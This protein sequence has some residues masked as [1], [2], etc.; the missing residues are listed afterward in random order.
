[1]LVL[2]QVDLEAFSSKSF[3]SILN[4][5]SKSVTS[6]IGL[7]KDEVK[8]LFQKILEQVF[9]LKGKESLVY[10]NYKFF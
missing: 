7:Q 3:Y 6:T 1:M 10:Q 4:N 9:S 8:S 2:L 5:Q